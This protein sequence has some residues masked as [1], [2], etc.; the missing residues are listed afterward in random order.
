VPGRGGETVKVI[1][2]QD[3]DGLGTAGQT[4]EAADGYARNFLFPR[5]LAEAYTPGAERRWAERARL[6]DRQRAR[7]RAEAEDLKARLDGQRVVVRVRAGE[8]GR[9]FG[10]VTAKDVAEAISRSLGAEVDRRRVHLERPIKA[11]G[12]HPVRID[13]HPHLSADVIVVVEEEGR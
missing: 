4:R 8:S 5:G 11:L 6:A 7:Q 1:L 9:T 3:V 12:E 13:V 2:L 10:A